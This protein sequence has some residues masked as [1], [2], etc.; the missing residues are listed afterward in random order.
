MLQGLLALGPVEDGRLIALR[1]HHGPAGVCLPRGRPDQG[2]A[3]PAGGGLRG[4]ATAPS[5]GSGGGRGP[6]RHR[7]GG[8]RTALIL[9]AGARS[10]RRSRGSRPCA[11]PSSRGVRLRTVPAHPLQERQL[12]QAPGA[13]ADVTLRHVCGRPGA[14]GLAEPPRGSPSSARPGCQRPAGAVSCWTIRP[15]GRRARSLSGRW[16]KPV[17]PGGDVAWS[18]LTFPR[19]ATPTH[20]RSP[21]KGQLVAGR[22]HGRRAS[23]MGRGGT[24]RGA[25]RGI[26]TFLLGRG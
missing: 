17:A 2:G 9:T 13:R 21:A 18:P 16:R 19:G 15:A 4:N 26:P 23:A 24:G 3:R 11:L 25:E 5:P 20:A 10:G 7:E 22:G 6:D 1:A 14:L 12:T 8:D